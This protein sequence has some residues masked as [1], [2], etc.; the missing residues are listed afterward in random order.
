MFVCYY[1]KK[2]FLPNSLQRVSWIFSSSTRL[3]IRTN[4]WF[5]CAWE[6][7]HIEWQH[8]ARH[9]CKWWT[10]RSIYTFAGASNSYNLK[11]HHLQWQSPVIGNYDDDLWSRVL[12]KFKKSSMLI[13]IIK[14]SFLPLSEHYTQQD[15][16]LVV[17]GFLT[18]DT[19]AR[20]FPIYYY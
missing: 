19:L 10:L 13:V 15:W 14:T 9:H 8:L 12:I 1:I 7:L 5:K 11:S 20:K 2:N 4:N 17:N 18:M 16:T 3:T 6:P